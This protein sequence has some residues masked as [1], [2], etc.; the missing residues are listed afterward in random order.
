MLHRL[1]KVGAILVWV[2]G[3]ADAALLEKVARPVPQGVK[4]TMDAIRELGMSMRW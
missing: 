2:F 4:V 1:A 3:D